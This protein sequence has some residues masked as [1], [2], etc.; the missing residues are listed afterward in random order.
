MVRLA[1]VRLFLTFRLLR[2]CPA[3]AVEIVLSAL[4]LGP[5][6]TILSF[7]EYVSD[8]KF[9]A[10]FSNVLGIIRYQLPGV[11][12]DNPLP[13][14]VNGQ[15][16]TIPSELYCYLGL[17]ALMVVGVSTRRWLFLAAFIAV[18][19]LECLLGFMPGRNYTAKVV[20]SPEGLVLCFLFGNVI[21]LFRDEIPSSFLLLLAAI[22]V[23]ALV[24]M[25]A[26]ALSL[27]FGVISITYITVFLGLQ[28]IPRVPILQSGD[29]SY[30]IYLY[31]FPLQQTVAWA[32]PAF[33]EWYWSLLIGGAA[34]ICFAMVSWHLLEKPALGLRKRFAAGPISTQVKPA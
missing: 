30:G 13:D 3:L 1:N 25:F 7:A 31:S 9:T 2:I 27:L 29:Y 28:S 20:S 24:L 5:L 23:T 4:L 32:S 11:F 17:A 21:Y 33:R 26:P 18:A 19:V 15:L 12:L 22:L 14:V 16:W 34:S 10:Y 6:V 8:A